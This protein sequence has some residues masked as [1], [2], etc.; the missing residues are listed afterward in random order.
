M[1]HHWPQTICCSYQQ[2]LGPCCSSSYSASCC[3]L[4]NIGQALYPNLA[5]TINSRLAILE[6]PSREQRWG[7]HWDEHKCACH[8]HI[9]KCTSMHIKRRHADSNPWEHRPPNTKIV[10]NTRLITLKR[11]MGT[12]HEALLAKWEWASGNGWWHCHE[13]QKNN[14]TFYIAKKYCSSCTATLR[15]LKRWLNFSKGVGISGGY[16]CRHEKYYKVV[17]HMLGISADNHMKRQYHMKYHEN[18]GMWLMLI[19]YN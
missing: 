9:G 12:K 13:G 18:L 16:E 2:G 19:F 3:I 8:Q 15:A 5:Q 17:C 6:E 4:G 11:W 1:Y 7:S 10:H 14:N